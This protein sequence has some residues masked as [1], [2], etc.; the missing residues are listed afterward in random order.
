[1]I[2]NEWIAGNDDISVPLRVREDV[3]GKEGGADGYDSFAMHLAVYSDGECVAAGR[4][5]VGDT[6]RFYISHICVEEDMRGQGIGDLTAKLLLYK[7]FQSAAAVRAEID[8]AL[9]GFFERYG[10]EKESEK[11]GRMTIVLKKEDAVYPSKCAG[12]GQAL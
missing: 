4:I 2:I 11:G 8:P 6:G 5:Y 1:M 9:Y 3:F 10:F 7:A 12:Q